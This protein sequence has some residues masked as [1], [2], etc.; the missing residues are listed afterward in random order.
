M[1]RPGRVGWG[2]SG[3]ILLETGGRRNGMRNYG[4]EDW[5]GD[6]YWSVKKR[7]KIIIIKKLR[8]SSLR[9]Y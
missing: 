6:K 5:E 7:L 4:R 1:R 8:P 3:D 2:W 9:A